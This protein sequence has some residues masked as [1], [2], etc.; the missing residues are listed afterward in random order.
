MLTEKAPLAPPPPPLIS[1]P[2]R[3]RLIWEGGFVE[4]G[5][6]AYLNHISSS[7]FTLIFQTSKTEQEISFVSPF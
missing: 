4:G 3:G 2:K 5:G 6:R 1:G 7:K